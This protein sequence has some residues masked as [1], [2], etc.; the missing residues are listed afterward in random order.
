MT[1]LPLHKAVTAAAAA[2]TRADK[3]L[4]TIHSFKQ[5]L[6]SRRLPFAASKHAILMTLNVRERKIFLMK[7][8]YYNN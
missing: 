1:S 8:F 2:T 7:H 4:S 6:K 3:H 5:C